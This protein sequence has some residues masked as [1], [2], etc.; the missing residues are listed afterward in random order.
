MA[1]VPFP[2]GAK[3]GTV[4]FHEDKVCI[5]SEALNTWE[6]RKVVDPNDPNRPD[7]VIYTTDVYVPDVTPNE[8]K[9]A[10]NLNSTF[11][12]L[13]GPEAR[14]PQTQADLNQE[15]GYGF[16]N[17]MRKA[18]RDRTRIDFIQNTVVEG[19]WDFDQAVVN[20]ELPESG[21]FN[22]YTEDGQ[23]TNDYGKV[24]EITFNGTDRDNK[25]NLAEVRRGATLIIFDVLLNSFAQFVIDDVST[26]GSIEGGQF[27]ATYHVRVAFGR[28][29]GLVPDNAP[30]EIKIVSPYPTITTRDGTAP[31]V[32]NDGY[33]WYNEVNKTL[34]VSDWDDDQDNNGDAVWIPVGGEGVSG[35]DGGGVHVSD[36]EPA[37]PIEGALWFDTGRL[38]LYVY[39]VE[40]EDGGWLPSSP[41][42]ARVSL[43]KHC[44]L[45]L[46]LALEL[47]NLSTYPRLVAPLLVVLLGLNVLM[48]LATGATSQ[49]TLN[50]WHTENKNHG[51]ILNIGTT[52]S[53]KQQFKI[54]GRSGKDLFEIHDDGAAVASLKG[55]LNISGTLK[56]DGN[57]ID[58]D[59]YVHK[60]G[61][62]QN[63]MQGDL[64]LGGFAI[65]GVG[66]PSL[67]TDAATKA[68]VDNAV[69]GGGGSFQTKYDGNRLCLGQDIVATTLVSQGQVAFWGDA[70]FGTTAPQNVRYIGFN[71]DEFNWD[72]CI[73][74]GIIRVRNGANDAGYYQVYRRTENSGRNMVLHVKPVW[75]DV[76]QVLE[77]DTGTPVYFQGVFFE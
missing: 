35:G 63:K 39:Y 58:D 36:Q 3:D 14:S 50:A 29:V 56:V 64:Y 76:N 45:R 67:S 11:K 65:K 73:G 40:D 48:T 42:G 2:N 54:Q 17:Q 75:T 37:D 46:I 66:E 23:P 62:T 10:L 44:R 72:S 4:F 52:N 38:E 43:V 70:S 8:T 41:L 51:I 31:I 16:L 33:L 32:D 15:I 13:N 24:A 71:I 9:R 53:F 22:M 69:T 27:W 74:S 47:L 5:Y 34:Y 55:N 57:T 28:N 30:C 21:S 18:T 77:G 1:E 6:C 49:L 7:D 61:G 20:A 19:D 25:N 60:K 68:Y 59:A 26:I 12:E